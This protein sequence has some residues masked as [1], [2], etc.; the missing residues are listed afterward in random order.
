MTQKQI[1]LNDRTTISV[2]ELLEA[3]KYFT[4][5]L[6]C[7]LRTGD[8]KKEYGEARYKDVRKLV[9]DLKITSVQIAMILNAIEDV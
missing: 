1:D 3:N 2:P 7:A 8:Q 5:V 4:R 6:G 9:R